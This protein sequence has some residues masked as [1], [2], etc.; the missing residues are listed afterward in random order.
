MCHFQD[1]YN[2]ADHQQKVFHLPPLI[3]KYNTY[4]DTARSN[5]PTNRE[6]HEMYLPKT[7]MTRKGAM[8][9]F[10][11]DYAAKTRSTEFQ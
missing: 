7:F 8:L 10:S 6:M 5:P 4:V 2:Y 9:L 11:E 1:Y 3:P